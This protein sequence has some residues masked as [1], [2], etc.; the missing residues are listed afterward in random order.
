[1]F[2]TRAN[3]RYEIR[4]YAT[5]LPFSGA[6][7]TLLTRIKQVLLQETEKLLEN[8]KHPDPY[9]PPTAPGGMCFDM[10][11]QPGNQ[12]LI[13]FKET[14]GNETCL[15]LFCLVSYLFFNLFWSLWTADLLII[16]MRS[17]LL[18]T[19]NPRGA[20]PSAMVKHL[21]KNT[22]TCIQLTEFHHSTISHPP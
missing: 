11:L 7:I 22:D 14:N 8:W 16:Q 19:D 21:T 12:S 3:S 15:L 2:A 13:L 5:R 17:L 6:K 10:A 20:A 18:P 4:C 1:M 9:R